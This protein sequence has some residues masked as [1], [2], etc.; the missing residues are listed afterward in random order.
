LNDL[1]PLPPNTPPIIVDSS[2][3]LKSF[4]RANKGAAPGPSGI[5]GI[6][7]YQLVQDKDIRNAMTPILSS[8]CN[9]TW[10]EPVAKS[11]ITAGIGVLLQKEDRVGGD[12]DTQRTAAEIL[13][14]MHSPQQYDD[15]G[16]L[17]ILTMVEH[18]MKV[19]G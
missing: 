19:A 2:A 10:N 16:R 3:I 14:M 13:S 5:S 17:R 11:F 15:N 8:I 1:P 7:W 9:G 6:V 12:D 4:K 18:I